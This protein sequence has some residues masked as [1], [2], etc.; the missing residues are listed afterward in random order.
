MFYVKKAKSDAVGPEEYSSEVMRVAD[1]APYLEN[2]WEAATRGEW[3]VVQSDEVKARLAAN[4][5]E[6]V[7]EVSEPSPEL[8]AEAEAPSAE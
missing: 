6:F 4:D 5:P 7:D 2:G 3:E 1:A 8:S